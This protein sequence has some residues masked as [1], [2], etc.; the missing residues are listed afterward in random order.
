[1]ATVA[2]IPPTASQSTQAQAALT[3]TKPS[4]TTPVPQPSITPTAG[5]VSTKPSPAT[6]P[7]VFSSNTNAQKE[8]QRQEAALPR[9]E[10]DVPAQ[11]ETKDA[12]HKHIPQPVI[13][14]IGQ[15]TK[16]RTQPGKVD[17]RTQP[18]SDA[19]GV[20]AKA[21][22]DKAEA[23][24]EPSRSYIKKSPAE[25]DLAT[26]GLP[27]SESTVPTSGEGAVPPATPAKT[28]A[29]V[30][31]VAGASAAAPATPASKVAAAES[32][33]G[34]VA[35]PTSTAPSTPAKPGKDSDAMRKRKSGFFAKVSRCG[36]RCGQRRFSVADHVPNTPGQERVQEGPLRRTLNG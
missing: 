25:K 30:A 17:N 35:T 10:H 29:P 31:T 21:E 9:S 15:S 2:G 28:G 36:S 24:G 14:S 18:I 13:T 1:V 11:H 8:G 4:T 20:S 27:L 26:S 33:E 3:P 6:H 23:D 12:N 19:P 7:D 32:R 16:D 34:A 22:K 5:G